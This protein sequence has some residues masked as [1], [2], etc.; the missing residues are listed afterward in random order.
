MIF[1][2]LTQ[3]SLSLIDLLPKSEG[4]PLMVATSSLTGTPSVHGGGADVDRDV[5]NESEEVGANVPATDVMTK[6]PPTGHPP[7][8]EAPWN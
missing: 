6:P 8:T 1:L 3:D 4:L 7:K 2:A 5:S